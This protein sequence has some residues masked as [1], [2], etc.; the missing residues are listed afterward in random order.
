MKENRSVMKI[1]FKFVNVFDANYLFHS[2]RAHLLLSYHDNT[3]MLPI[4]NPVG[5]QSTNWMVLLVLM[6]AMARLIS[7]IIVFYVSNDSELEPSG[8]Q[9]GTGTGTEA[10]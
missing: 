2:A 8:T 1:N 10:G 3:M 4:L 9:T 6:L 7:L 5:H